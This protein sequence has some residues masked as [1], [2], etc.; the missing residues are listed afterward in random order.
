MENLAVDLVTKRIVD[1][2]IAVETFDI[3]IRFAARPIGGL[4]LKRHNKSTQ[5]LKVFHKARRA[6]YN[7]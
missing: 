1:S 2:E 4:T 3:I 7:M 6:R 5:K